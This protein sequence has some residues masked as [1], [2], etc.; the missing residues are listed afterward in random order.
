N[1]F[2]NPT[3]A[4]AGGGGG[5]V[6][7]IA[8]NNFQASIDAAANN[9]DI[10][11][12][13]TPRI[14][15]RSGQ[16]AQIQ[17]GADVPVISS[18]GAANVDLGQGLLGLTSIDY[19]STGILLSIEP[20]VYG[21]NRVDLTVSQELSNSSAGTVAGIPSPT[22]SNTSVSTALSLEDGA[23]AVIG[24][25]IQETADITTSGVPFLKDI[26]GLGNLFSTTS[27]DT[28]KREIVI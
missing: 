28:S 17:V 20:I 4:I 3:S 15:T 6:A 9:G 5:L 7:S 25:L 26:P 16:G 11:I 27:E 10:R 24:G 8:N 12:L 14:I 22:F 21:N 19:R 1:L 13:S 2:D 23:T 18:Q